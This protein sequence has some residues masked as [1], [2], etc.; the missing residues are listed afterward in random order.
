MNQVVLG[1]TL[2]Y[3]ALAALL[4]AIFILTR[5]PVWIKLICVLLVT[6]F[7]FL[8]YNNLQGVLGWPTQQLMPDQFQL[9]ASTITEPN[10]DEGIEGSIHIWATSFIDNKPAPEPRAYALPYDLD[11]HTALE[12]ALKEQR[13]GNIQLGKRKGEASDDIASDLSKYGQKRQELEF[14]DLPDPE[15]PEK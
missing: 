12:A 2:T 14:F 15:L 3:A 1:L 13:R 7:Y 11:L 9:L 6:G 10:D 5:I 4:L 8:T